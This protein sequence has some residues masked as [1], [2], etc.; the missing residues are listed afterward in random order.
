MAGGR[1]AFRLGRTTR[2]IICL[3]RTSIYECGAGRRRGTPATEPPKG[4][5]DTRF[6]TPL[7]YYVLN[8]AEI[9]E[10]G[11]SLGPLGAG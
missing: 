11:E 4:V 1:R 2:L 8:E 10:D 3:R 6:T 5:K 7:W 9:L